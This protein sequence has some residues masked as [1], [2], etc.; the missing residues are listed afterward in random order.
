MR[1][2]FFNWMKV[3]VK[4]HIRLWFENLNETFGT[5]TYYSAKQKFRDLIKIDIEGKNKSFYTKISNKVKGNKEKV[6]V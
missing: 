5:E 6:N 4:R 3:D 1:V 2:Q